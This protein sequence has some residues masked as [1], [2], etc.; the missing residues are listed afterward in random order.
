MSTYITNVRVFDGEHVL[1]ARTVGID[2]TEI[3][4]VGQQPPQDA[5]LVDGQGGTLLPGLI[6]GHVHTSLEGLRLALAFGVTTE[7]E[8]QG[9]WTP[10]QRA[11]IGADDEIADVRSALLA[12]MAPG[13]HPSELMGDLGDHAPDSGGWT[14][15]SVSTPQEAVAYVNAR[16]AEGADYIKVMIEDGAVM[17]HP[18]LPMISTETL[19]AGVA[20]A[21]RLG[22]QVIAHALTVAA[23]QQ[24]LDVGVDGFAHLFID[25]AHTPQI[26]AAIADAGVFVTPCLAVSASVMGGTGAVLAEDPRVERRLPEPWLET[27]RGTFNTFPDGRFEDVLGSAAALRDAGVDII[28]G[29]DSSVPVP[30]HGGVVH[31]ASLHHELQLLVRAGLSPQ[32]ALRAAT[33]TPAR[34]FGLTDRGRIAPGARADLLLVDGDPTTRIGDS[35]SIRTIWRRGTA[36]AAH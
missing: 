3:V 1:D 25:Q 29:T 8:M 34:R 35:L 12:L 13:G 19:K 31:G 20:E 21:H 15:P 22:K 4:S 9:Y 36:T 5:E 16:V 26:I 10:E 17:G 11:Q 7:L 32:E 18:G 27:L 24:A 14:M 6:D 28:A 23:T 2:G 33:G 30:S